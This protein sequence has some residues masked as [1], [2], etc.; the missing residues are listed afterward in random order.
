MYLS[1]VEGLCFRDGM[2][3]LEEFSSLCRALF[4]TGAGS[5]YPLDANKVAHM[6]SIFDTDEV[7]EG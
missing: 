5:P 4:R 1:D 7:R 3:N 6:F 2:L